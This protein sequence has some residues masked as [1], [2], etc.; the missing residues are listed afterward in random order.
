ME[1]NNMK[2]TLTVLALV[3]L[4]VLVLS[5]TAFAF[6][7]GGFGSGQNRFCFRETL[8]E[9]Q[10]AQFEGII[11]QYRAKMTALREKMFALRS[12]G[13][14]EGFR[15]AQA[16]RY[17]LMEQ[18]REE[19]S[20]IFPDEYAERFQNQNCG[21]QMRNFGVQKGSSGFGMKGGFNR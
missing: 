10:Q 20:E 19:L 6:Y 9:E 1:V 11:E 21:R 8:T 12:A 5:S 17:E 7:G 14:S 16:E 13:D 3:V 18:K 2:K 15:E 4:S